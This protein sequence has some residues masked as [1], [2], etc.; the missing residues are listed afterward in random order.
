MEDALFS[1]W[2]NERKKTTTTTTSTKRK[3]KALFSDGLGAQWEA[4]WSDRL[5]LWSIYPHVLA[6]SSRAGGEG[7]PGQ[8]AWK[9]RQSP[10]AIAPS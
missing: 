3:R 2:G 10:M 7:Y 9:K 8:N 5:V 6:S 1:P 4:S